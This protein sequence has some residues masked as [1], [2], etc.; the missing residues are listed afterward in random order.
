[1]VKKINFK[2][3]KNYT[4]FYIKYKNKDNSKLKLFNL[5]KELLNYL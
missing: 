5:I 2:T 3:L 1:M 4:N